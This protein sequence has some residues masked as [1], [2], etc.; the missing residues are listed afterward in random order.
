MA[1]RLAR[2]TGTSMQSW[3]AMQLALDVWEAEQHPSAW[4]SNPS[5]FKLANRPEHLQWSI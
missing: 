5:R 1:Q 3:L 2:A 4:R